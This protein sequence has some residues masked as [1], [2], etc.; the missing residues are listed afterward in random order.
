MA[1]GHVAIVWERG[2]VS[3][4]LTVANGNRVTQT[5]AVGKGDAGGEHFS[6]GLSGPCR[7]EVEIDQARLDPGSNATLVTVATDEQPFSFFLRDVKAERP[8][9]IPAYGVAVT[10][11]GDKRS[12]A[13]IAAAIKALGLEST[14][15]RIAREP[16]ETYENAAAHTRS[17]TGPTWLGLSRDIHLFELVPKDEYG[18]G[19]E[20]A[21]RLHGNIIKL[22]ETEPHEAKYAF[23]LG[24]GISCVRPVKRRIEGGCLPILLS[25][26]DDEDIT[27]SLTSFVTLEKNPLRPDTLRG[28]HYLAADGHSRGFNFTEAQQ[29]AFDEMR[30]AEEQREEETVLCV[31]AEAVNTAAVPRYAWFKALRPP[32]TIPAAGFT[33]DGESGFGRYTKSGRVYCIGRLNGRPMPQSEIAVLLQPGEKAVVEMFVPHQPLS[34]ERAAALAEADFD[35]RHAECRAFWQ[36]KLDAGAQLELPETVINEMVRAGLL[37]LDMIAYGLEP[38]GSVTPTVGIYSAIGSES[39][40]ITQFFDSMGR[41]ALAERTLNYFLDKQRPDGFMQNF[42]TYTLETGAALWSMGEHWRTTRDEA[43]VRGIKDK[44]VLACDYMLAWRERNKRPEFEGR[45][46]GLQE[47]KVADPPDPFHS[48]M[49][50]GYAYIGMARVAE[51]L[52]AVDP[53]ESER[54]AREAEAFKADI[55]TAFFEAMARAPVVPLGDGSWVPTAPPWAE[56]T[57]PMA[58]YAE[59]GEWLTHATFMTRDSLVGPLYLMLQEVL[60]PDEP[61]AKFMLQWHSELMCVRNVGHSQP[62][63]CRHDYG[64]LVRGEVRAFLKTYYNALTALADRETYSFWEHF[65]FASPHKTHE[66]AWFLMQTRWMLWMERGETLRLL[67]AVPRA[68]LEHGKRIALKN[69]ATY[70]GPM[71]LTVESHVDE[72]FIEATVECRTDRQ[73]KTIALRLPHPQERKAKSVEG[74]EYDPVKETVRIDGFKDTATVRVRF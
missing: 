39:A 25:T 38:D 34:D 54:W 56:G 68:W 60:D 2:P 45:G 12:Y 42:N 19:L 49:L 47:G 57:G 32:W 74:G 66:E 73:P 67:Q 11:A 7:I 20:I 29:H 51:M 1:T 41:H 9:F 18:C 55:R 26:A 6:I 64:H 46:W 10:D 40:P 63:Y 71:S 48:F 72:G 28:T 30:Q 65:H 50:N 62:Y 53:K 15:E 52:R 58:L 31:R 4:A 3:G 5:V 61:A 16:E 36:K 33:L 22:P 70:F 14:L 24:R 69:V 21:P 27:Y 44:L 35:T 8:I 13:E 23:H 17:L 37:H 59:P 43:W